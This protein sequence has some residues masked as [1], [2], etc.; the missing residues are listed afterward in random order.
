VNSMVL[1]LTLL[2]IVLLL[3]VLLFTVKSK[4][5]F[6]FNSSSADMHLTLF[7][8]YPLLKSVITREDNSPVVTVY[9][10]NKRILTKKINRKQNESGK[11]NVLKSLHPTDIHVDTQYGFRDPFITGLACS[12]ITLASEFFNVES[13]NQKPDF[14]A[15]NDY[16]NLDATAKLN[17]GYSLIKLI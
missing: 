7:W 11:E 9:L 10:L 5:D 1:L 17:L 15:I 12:A 4:V 2:M 14:L 6:I 16:I 8:L 3:I 13:L